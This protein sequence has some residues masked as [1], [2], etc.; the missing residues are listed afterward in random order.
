MFFYA[1]LDMEMTV[2]L[3]IY[4]IPTSGGNALK[5]GLGKK[6]WVWGTCEIIPSLHPDPS[7]LSSS[8]IPN[9]QDPMAKKRSFSDLSFSTRLR[10]A[11]RTGAGEVLTRLE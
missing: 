9:S 1:Q 3:E 6:K 8:S 7:P 5:M 10:R 2:L 11:P 4:R